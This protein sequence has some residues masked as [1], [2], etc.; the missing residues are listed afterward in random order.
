MNS[1]IL[2]GIGTHLSK[3]K[4]HSQGISR[5][6]ENIINSHLN[7]TLKDPTI[8]IKQQA[9]CIYI[10]IRIPESWG[11]KITSEWIQIQCESIQEMSIVQS[12]RGNSWLRIRTDHP[13]RQAKRSCQR[14]QEVKPLKYGGACYDCY[15]E[16]IQEHWTD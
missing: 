4:S 15:I 8:R 7:G 1:S 5:T 13:S 16:M 11:V 9:D 6:V 10:H 12:K 14:C 2:E 3:I